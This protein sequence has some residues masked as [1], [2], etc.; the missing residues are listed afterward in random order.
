[1]VSRSRRA[2]ESAMVFVPDEVFAKVEMSA[3]LYS[4]A[5][6]AFV[7]LAVK[8]PVSV[9]IVC[10]LFPVQLA[11]FVYLH[12]RSVR[13]RRRV[14]AEL[15]FASMVISVLSHVAQPNL[16][17]A[18]ARLGELGDEVFPGFSDE[19]RSLR[20][21]L[22]YGKMAETVTLERSFASH[23]SDLL[24]EFVR[25][26]MV[27]LRSGGNVRLFVESESERLAELM[28]ARWRAFST[29]LGSMTEVAFILLAV[30]PLGMEMIAGAFERSEAG[31][32]LV[33]SALMLAL[34]A[35][36]LILWM[37][38]AQPCLH[39]A[40]YPLGRLALGAALLASLLVL[41]ALGIFD[42]FV[43]ASLALAVSAAYVASSRRF[44]GN[45]R[46]GERETYSML[47]FLAEQARAGASL[48]EA[49]GRLQEESGGYPSL[50]DQIVG[51]SRMVS[52]G[53]SPHEAARRVAHPSWLVR[54]SFAVLAVSFETGAGYGQLER[55]SNSFKNIYDARSST[56]S[57][58]LPF[59]LLGASVPVISVASYTF[60]R[61]M[62][63]FDSLLPGFSTGGGT[64]TVSF[65]ILLSSLLT[66]AM[67]S[68][69]YSLSVRSMEG[70]PPILLSAAA[71]F[72]IFGIL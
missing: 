65:S 47:H 69:A 38:S 56:R 58:V 1:M 20:R 12:A 35:A 31:T 17:D 16:P 2:L 33:I 23:P 45:L 11:P 25:G 43:A 9:A 26:Y 60:L 24:R 18:F 48:P 36:G 50:K 34:V 30:F 70:L 66:G 71:S 19:E 15:P 53:T 57:S 54:V 13:R 10:A 40:K 59:A 55:L 67:V 44:F 61:G 52:L 64:W 49:V 41:Y 51:F 28:E 29:N 4:A 32:L 21:N 62:Q 42:A 14:E 5:L 7:V 68:K 6:Q 72:L 3:L 46:L 39:D 27:A 37:D 8:A 22:A 63:V